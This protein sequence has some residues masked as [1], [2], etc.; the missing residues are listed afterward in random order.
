MALALPEMHVLGSL[1]PDGRLLFATRVVRMAAYGTLSVVLALY[2]TEIGLKEVQI[3]LL[4]SLTLF[5]DVI[6]SAVIT[7]V[8]DRVGRRYMLMLG[9]GLMVLAG[10]VF[11]LTRHPAVLTLA[12]IIGTISPSGAEVGPFLA[13]E[14]AMLP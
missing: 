9:A 2:L 10:M 12:A 3:G 6:I 8:T 1:T 13:I 11:A 7:S 5:G 14:Q 4:L